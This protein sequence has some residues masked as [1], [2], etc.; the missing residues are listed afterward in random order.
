MQDEAAAGDT[1][2]V[3]TARP[4]QI[5]LCEDDPV[6]RLALE[7]AVTEMGHRCIVAAKNR[8]EALEE[9]ASKDEVDLAILDVDLQGNRSTAVH[10]AL[11]ALNIPYILFTGFDRTQLQQMGFTATAMRKPARPE[12]VVAFA[13]AHAREYWM[14]HAA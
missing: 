8:Y 9:L 6:I 3:R 11:R 1:T 7:D 2:E 12:D 5:F 13:L 14:R 10:D 4:A